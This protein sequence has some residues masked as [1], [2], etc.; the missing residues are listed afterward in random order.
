MTSRATGAGARTRTVAYGPSLS[1]GS[2]TPMARSVPDAARRRAGELRERIRRADHAYYVLDRPEMADSEYDALYRELAAL[3]AEH[4]GLVDPASPTQRV[5][6]EVAEGFRSVAHPAPMVSIEN[7]M[8][9]EEFRDWVVSTDR[10]LKSESPRAYSVEPKIDGVSLELIYEHGVLVTAATRGDGTV[11]EDVTANARTLRSI[12]LRLHAAQPPAYVAVRG[13]AY[14]AKADFERLNRELVEA[15]EEG[16]ANPRNCCA[17]S[18]RQL[19]PKIPASRPIRYVAYAVAAMRGATFATQTEVLEALAAWGLPTNHETRN[20]RGADGVVA[21]HRA[22]A[23]G[24]DGLAYEIDG[25]VVKEDDLALQ[26]RLGLRNRSPRWAVAWKF[27]ARQAVTRV[28]RVVWSVGRTGVVTPSADLEPVALAGVTVS[29]ATLHNVDEL[30][31]LGLREG[32]RVVLERA[33]DVIPKVLRVLTDERTGRER[34]VRVPAECPE[35]STALERA[36]GK[37]ALR[38]PNLSCPAQAVRLLIHFAGRL[39][40]DIRGLGEKQADLLWREGLVKDPGDLFRLQAQDLVPL[41]RF[42][43]KSAANLVAQIEQARSVSL[44]RLLFALGIPEVGERAARVLARAFG[45]LERLAEASR[46]DLIEI[47]EVGE[48]L[49]ATVT[50]WFARPQ[51][52]RLLTKLREGGVRPTPLEAPRGGAF[53][54]LTVVL[55]GTL[56]T[57]SRDEAKALVEA[58]GG[59]AGSSVSAKTNLVVAGPGAGSKLKQAQQLGIEVIGEAEFMKRAGRSPR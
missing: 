16:F 8:S 37:V 20:V 59:R 49:A 44:D 22:L 21:R 27:P 52:R 30:R 25:V 54:G 29:R 15:G 24:R 51:N 57:L 1:L 32:D 58:Q 35:C 6:G 10:F 40:A 43:E 47:D 36:E 42:G 17:G 23:E 33:G 55:T 26:E 48:A 9:E 7:V 39:G 34:A 18:L 4:P 38:C 12:P 11:G 3:E 28:A 46:E 45:T 31:R 5:P 53:A 41:E 14:L 2:L 13:E 56:E 50:S 19:D